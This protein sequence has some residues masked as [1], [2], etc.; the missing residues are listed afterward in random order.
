MRTTKRSFVF[1]SSEF[2]DGR[3]EVSSDSEQI[4]PT[5]TRL[6]KVRLC[7]RGANS[8]Q[9]EGAEGEVFFDFV[10]QSQ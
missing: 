10:M 5:V 4:E 6:Q 1:G 9:R 2:A 7:E 8:R 3:H